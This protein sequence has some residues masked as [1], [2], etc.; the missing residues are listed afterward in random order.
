[1]FTA[2][3]FTMGENEPKAASMENRQ[4]QLLCLLSLA[5]LSQRGTMWH[6]AAIPLSILA[7]LRLLN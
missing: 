3:L 4:V 5:F 2:A 7:S 6:N 1:M